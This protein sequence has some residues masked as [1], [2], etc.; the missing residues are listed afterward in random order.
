MSAVLDELK[1][2]FDRW[3]VTASFQE[4]MT[5]ALMAAM[6]FSFIVVPILG[7]LRGPAR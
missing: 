3:W 1:E 2:D 4:K 5:M 7:L 6:G